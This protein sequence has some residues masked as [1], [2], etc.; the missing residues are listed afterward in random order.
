M[1]TP[2]GDQLDAITRAAALL[3]ATGPAAAAAITALGSAADMRVALRLAGAV[4]D[5]KPESTP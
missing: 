3:R 5:D 2:A 4:N 1:T